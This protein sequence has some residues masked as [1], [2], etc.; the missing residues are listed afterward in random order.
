MWQLTPAA[1]QILASDHHMVVAYAEVVGAPDTRIRL[2]SGEVTAKWG[3]TYA[4]SLSCTVASATLRPATRDALLAPWGT[5]LRVWRGI[6]IPALHTTEMCALGT[7]YL[8]PVKVGGRDGLV[9]LTGYD[10]AWRADRPS[11]RPA[12]YAAGSRAVDVIADLVRAQIPDL[13][14]QLPARTETVPPLL[15]HGDTSPWQTARQIARDVLAGEL[16][17][18]RLGQLRLIP[19]VASD[20]PDFVVESGARG[21]I[22]GDLTYNADLVHNDVVVTS[23]NPAIGTIRARA[24]DLDPASPT[25]IR[26]TYGRLTREIVTDIASTQTQVQDLATRTL[27]EELGRTTTL[28]DAE[29]VPHPGLDPADIVEITSPLRGM[30]S[31]RLRI[32]DVTTPVGTL[33][34]QKWSAT[35][36]ILTPTTGEGTVT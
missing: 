21:L 9:E 1:E 17:F 26:G 4:R 32:T 8:V 6:Q 24:S 29:T 25:Y 23:T 10:Y 12:A 36:S 13:V 2:A 16:L 20:E 11:A 18:D 14:S 28:V 31:T 27:A 30:T 34:T 7:F 22:A 19:S 3:E 35:S 5:R 15:I 33:G